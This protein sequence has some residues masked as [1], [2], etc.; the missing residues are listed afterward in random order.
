MCQSDF[1]QTK[2]TNSL[3]VRQE[4]GRRGEWEGPQWGMGEITERDPNENWRSRSTNQYYY[5]ADTSEILSSQNTKANKEQATPVLKF[6]RTLKWGRYC[7]WQ[8]R[9]SI[10]PQVS[11]A[12]SSKVGTAARREHVSPRT[13]SITFQHRD[14]KHHQLLPSE[15][16]S[17]WVM[18]VRDERL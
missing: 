5:H 2:V 7:A 16:I 1:I 15:F 8:E 4:R 11:G 10:R 14:L 18:R 6:L 3:S 13:H 17:H 9:G 12:P